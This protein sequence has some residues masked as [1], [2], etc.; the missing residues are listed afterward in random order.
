MIS[1]IRPHLVRPQS[2]GRDAIEL[3]IVIHLLLNG[4]N[5]AIDSLDLLLF[6]IVQGPLFGLTLGENGVTPI[7]EGLDSAPVLHHFK[8]LVFSSLFLIYA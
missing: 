3:D 6:A 7:A 4:I 8:H 5:P 2:F 1:D